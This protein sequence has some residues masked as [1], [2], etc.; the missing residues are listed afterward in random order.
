LHLDDGQRFAGLLLAPLRA[1]ELTES[2]DE[3]WFRNPR[4]VDQLRSEAALPP[5]C[6]VSPEELRA[7]AAALHRTLLDAL[8]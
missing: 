1:R 8:S 4:G 5:Q 6:E 3:D 2:H 7:G